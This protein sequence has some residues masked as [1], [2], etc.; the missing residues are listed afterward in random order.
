MQA[1]TIRKL[2]DEILQAKLNKGFVKL[3]RLLILICNE[4][5]YLSLN[6]DFSRTLQ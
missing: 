1:I 4:T 6:V 2:W 3:L 5:H